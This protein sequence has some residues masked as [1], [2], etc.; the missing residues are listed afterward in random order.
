MYGAHWTFIAS[1]DHAE[2]VSHIRTLSSF[3]RPWAGRGKR[4]ENWICATRFSTSINNMA[5]HS[6]FHLLIRLYRADQIST[7]KFHSIQVKFSSWHTSTNQ[8]EMPAI[9]CVSSSSATLPPPP[10]LTSFTFFCFYLLPETADSIEFPKQNRL[11]SMKDNPLVSHLIWLLPPLANAN[12]TR[13]FFFFFICSNRIVPWSTI[14]F[15]HF[16]VCNTSRIIFIKSKT[17]TW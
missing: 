14:K 11:N 9:F 6:L 15:Q 3:T 8:L 16:I 12:T 1:I 4:W 17:L 2:N 10:P 5:A 13:T 7:K